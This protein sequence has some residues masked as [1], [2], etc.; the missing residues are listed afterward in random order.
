VRTDTNP[1]QGYFP[2]EQATLEGA[3]AVLHIS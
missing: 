3:D 1:R 2:L